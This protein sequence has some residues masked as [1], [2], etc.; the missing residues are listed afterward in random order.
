MRTVPP[1]GFPVNAAGHLTVGGVDA[2]ELAGEYGTPLHVLDEDRLRA[3]CREYRD[4]LRQ[5]YP[6]SR[7]VFASKALCV[8]ATCQI[9]HQEGLGI[10]VASGGEL[11]TARRA[12]IP[13]EDLVF[14]GN[15]K[16]PEEISYALRERVGRFVVD[17]EDEL[18]LLDELTARTGTTADILL[19]ITPGIEPHTHRAVQ[20]GGVDSK[21]GFAL[22]D[23]AADRAAARAA[24]LDRVRLRGLHAHVGSQVCDLEPFRLEAAALVEFAARLRDA[25]AIAVE[26]LNLGGGLGIRYLSSDEPPSKAAY[27]RT[28]VD[29]VRAKVEAHRLTPPTLYIEPGRSI[30]GDAGV[31]LYRVGGVK[32]IPGVRTYVTVDG[33]M[34]ENPRPALYGARYEAVLAAQP[35]AG[36]VQT[37][38]L[39]GRCCESG[40]V[41]I[42]EARLP[43]VRRGDILAVFSTGA[44][45]YSMASNYNRFPRPAVVL[46]GGGRARVIVERED[47]DDLVR[48]DVLL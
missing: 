19:R 34:Y 27:I 32:T 1:H 7:V 48:K 4:L 15:N 22:A 3:N 16:T 37:V 42:W 40:D 28:L 45:H 38:A 11:Y 26:E 31:T 10:D 21:F 24:A 47:Y 13:A 46:A 43:E 33:G 2:L 6:R 14:H 44:Y 18:S 20:T 12:G 39:A 23:G 41:L 8:G 36:P 30:V 9:A 29:T 35:L 5:A 17:N 25:L